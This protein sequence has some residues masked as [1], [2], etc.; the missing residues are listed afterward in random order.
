MELVNKNPKIYIFSGKARAGKDSCANYIK[1]FCEKN[2]KKYLCLQYSRYLKEY[3]KKITNWDGNDETKPRQLLIDLGTNLI[4]NKLNKYMLV[5]RMIE[6]IRVMSY[7]F[8][9]I[10]VSDARLAEELDIPREK[11][12]NVKIINVIRP[13]FDN[14]LTAEQKKT[15]TEIGLDDYDN[16]DYKII[17][18][19]T[20]DDLRS[21][22]I[23][24]L[25]EIN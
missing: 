24:M 13:N 2:N 11:L 16:Y 21:K 20:L 4:R 9:V 7:F 3:A 17:N 18:D 22:V 5:N 12:D 25:E 14:N 15:L 19:D 6:D 8:D 23:K 10:V 1:E